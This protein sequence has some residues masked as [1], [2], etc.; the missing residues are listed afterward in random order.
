MK[1]R[2]ALIL[3]ASLM[4]ATIIGSEMFLTGCSN[5]DKFTGKFTENDIK[6]LDEVGEVILPNTELSPGAKNTQI[7]LFME[8]IVSDCYDTEEQIVFMN[9]IKELNKISK[10]NK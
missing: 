7:G 1:R 8:A 3:T 10:Q 5:K 9:G 2:K 4:G 6:L